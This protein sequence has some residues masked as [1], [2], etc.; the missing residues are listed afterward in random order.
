MTKYEDMT[1]KKLRMLLASGLK[2]DEYK[3]AMK[4]W[5]KRKCGDE[6]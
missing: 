1:N 6:V 3:A 4:E 5:M 2:K